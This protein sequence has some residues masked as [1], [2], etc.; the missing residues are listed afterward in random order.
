MIK[1]IA[2][3]LLL[4]GSI[5][6]QSVSYMKY[7]VN[8]RTVILTINRQAK[9]QSKE[10]ELALAFALGRGAIHKYTCDRGDLF[11]GLDRWIRCAAQNVKKVE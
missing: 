10:F 9:D 4:A 11:D 5:A 6:A 2:F 7:E 1:I 8:G 3:I